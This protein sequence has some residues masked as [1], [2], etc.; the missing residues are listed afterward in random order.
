MLGG[1]V[2]VCDGGGDDGTGDGDDDGTSTGDGDADGDAY[3][4]GDGL[5][6]VTMT[7]RGRCGTHSGSFAVSAVS[8]E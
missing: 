5:T 8:R 2:G 4:D 7:L 6:L 1:G 3:P